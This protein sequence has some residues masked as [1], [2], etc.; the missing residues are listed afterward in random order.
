VVANFSSS[1]ISPEAYL[2]EEE[3]SP[4]K[5]EYRDGQIYAMAGAL[6]ATLD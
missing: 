3:N 2:A 4:V 6:C 1:Y 5:H